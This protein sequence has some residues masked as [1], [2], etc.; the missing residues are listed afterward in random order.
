M[1]TPFRAAF[2]APSFAGKEERHPIF[3]DAFPGGGCKTAVELFSAAIRD[4]EAHV[5]RLILDVS[6]EVSP[7]G[8][9]GEART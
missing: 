4:L 7:P 2:Q 8:K 3:L 6:P 9:P 1:L 5:Q